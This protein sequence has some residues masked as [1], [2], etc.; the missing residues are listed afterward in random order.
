MT[1]KL[2][3]YMTDISALFPAPWKGKEKHN[4]LIT[5]TFGFYWMSHIYYRDVTTRKGNGY[6]AQF[7][8]I[9]LDTNAPQV[10]EYDCQ[11]KMFEVNWVNSSGLW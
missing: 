6:F 9:N 5:L 3:F 4:L 8:T 11:A 2:S 7:R 1:T 10:D